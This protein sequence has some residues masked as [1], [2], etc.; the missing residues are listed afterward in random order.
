MHERAFGGC[1]LCV[2][3]Q[4]E[5]LKGRDG[6]LDYLVYAL[7]VGQQSAQLVAFLFELATRLGGQGSVWKWGTH[8]LREV[9][10]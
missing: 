9:S 8:E 1:Y 6:S 2:G 3:G 4:D 10:C 5:L 7:S